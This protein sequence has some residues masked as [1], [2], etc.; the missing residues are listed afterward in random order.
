MKEEFATRLNKAISIRGFKQA[1]L[2]EKTGLSKSA[3]SQYC[4]GKVNATQTPL[5]KL[6]NALSVSESWLMGYD[7]EMERNTRPATI[8]LSRADNPYDD[9]P[10][11]AQQEIEN[12]IA[13]TRQKYKKQD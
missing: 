2:V 6:A 10:E 8:A 4:S 9:L 5:Y 11:E 3:I 13:Y 7:V 1:D 12:F